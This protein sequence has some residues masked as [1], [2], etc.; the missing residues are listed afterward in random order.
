MWYL[1]GVS[2][3]MILCGL[4]W[5]GGWV[6][7]CL[8]DGCMFMVLMCVVGIGWICCLVCLLW[9]VLVLV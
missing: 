5:I 2:V 6:I 4:G 7:G 1:G 3:L 9:Y 8:S